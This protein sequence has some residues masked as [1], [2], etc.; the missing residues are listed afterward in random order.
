V[1]VRGESVTTQPIPRSPSDGS[2]LLSARDE[3]WTYIYQDET[4]ES[5][6]YDRETDP[7]ERNPLSPDQVAPA[8]IDRLHD[9]VQ[10][11]LDRIHNSTPQNEG[12]HTGPPESVTDHLEHLGYS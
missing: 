3:R 5:E 11:R 12:Q 6:L 2:L 7:G 8:T 9:A 10:T 1:T 4:E